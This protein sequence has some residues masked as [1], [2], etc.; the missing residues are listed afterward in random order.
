MEKKVTSKN[1]SATAGPSVGPSARML[2]SQSKKLSKQQMTHDY[3]QSLFNPESYNSG[4]PSSAG[5]SRTTKVSTYQ[6]T[7]LTSE[8]SGPQIGQAIFAVRFGLRGA[9]SSNTSVN[10]GAPGWEWFTPPAVDCQTVKAKG[11]LCGNVSTK[12]CIRCSKKLCPQCSLDMSGCHHRFG[13]PSDT[14][15]TS[16][17]WIFNQWTPLEEEESLT[18]YGASY[19]GVGCKVKITPRASFIAMAGTL[20]SAQIP[21]DIGLPADVDGSG[22][23]FTWNYDSVAVLKGAVTNAAIE[24]HERVLLPYSEDAYQLKPTKPTQTFQN[25]ISSTEFF[26]GGEEAPPQSLPAGLVYPYAFSTITVP[27]G[28]GQY[29]LSAID[30]DRDTV[31]GYP[32]YLKALMDSG[33]SYSDAA[34]CQFYDRLNQ[35]SVQNG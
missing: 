4:V 33:A 30:G 15:G 10:S 32:V 14:Y 13:A 3:V 1:K 9:Y 29:A 27:G 22:A 20:V 21:G 18:A 2:T 34:A 17:G 7:T 6:K 31:M 16:E 19:R 12:T 25:L 35:M 24:G 23:S 8:A 26:T 5:K 28:P 11:F